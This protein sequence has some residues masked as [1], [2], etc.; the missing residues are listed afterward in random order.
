MNELQTSGGF[1]LS[2]MLKINVA[3]IV[4]L[5]EPEG[6]QGLARLKQGGFLGGVYKLRLM[7]RGIV[8]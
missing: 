7:R 6:I 8:D 1:C 2:S 5:R 4:I 3:G